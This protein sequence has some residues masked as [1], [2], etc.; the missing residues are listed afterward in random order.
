MKRLYK[1]K[2][3]KIVA[4]IICG[5]GEYTDPGILVYIVSIFLV[6]HKLDAR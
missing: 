4:G 6:P 2:D 3:N 5:I 1:S